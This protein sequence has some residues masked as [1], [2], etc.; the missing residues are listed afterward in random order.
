MPFDTTRQWERADRETSKQWLKSFAELFTIHV[1]MHIDRLAGQKIV[2][3]AKQP[4][5]AP[6]PKTEVAHTDG[7][8]QTYP[9]QGAPAKVNVTVA[10]RKGKID[11]R[12]RKIQSEFRKLEKRRPGM[13][14]SWYSK[15]LAELEIAGG[16]DAETI[17]KII[18]G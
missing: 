4:K 15:Q 7:P 14:N 5:P 18:R 10:Y 1:K 13:S 11:K 16:L 12:N 9:G 17:R 8:A 2:E 6:E 3:L